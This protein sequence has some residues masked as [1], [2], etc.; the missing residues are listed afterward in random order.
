M[1]LSTATSL[2]V[3][4]FSDTSLYGIN[5]REKLLALLAEKPPIGGVIVR[6]LT[7]DPKFD[8]VNP[9][10]IDA[11]FPT[12]VEPSLEGAR[13]DKMVG[14]R[15][16]ILAQLKQDNRRAA[17]AA[18]LLLYGVK[19]PEEQRK[20]WIWALAQVWV[21]PDDRHGYAVVLGVSGGERVARLN[22][23]AGVSAY[24]R[25]LSFPL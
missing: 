19:N 11:N 15:E 14:S 4:L 23:V 12:T 22:D 2:V 6:L 7:L 5:K 17:N 20:Y 10:I 9:N 25:I 16:S 1:D 8:Y 21:G 18:E 24:D 3:D 13:L